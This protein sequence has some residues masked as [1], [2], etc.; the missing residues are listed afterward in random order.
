M[1]SNEDFSNKLYL[2][3]LLIPDPWLTS[4]SI[5]SL[6]PVRNGNCSGSS[7]RSPWKMRN[8]ST[9][10]GVCDMKATWM[11]RLFPEN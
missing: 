7:I 1:R 11:I 3:I 5:T 6:S 9:V 10:S 2:P 4:S 8:Q